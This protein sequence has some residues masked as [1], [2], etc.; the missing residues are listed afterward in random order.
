MNHSYR[1]GHCY[2]LLTPIAIIALIISI[3]LPSLEQARYLGKY[4]SLKAQATE[5]GA[6]LV[7][8]ESKEARDFA[9]LG[10][11]A[12]AK[13]TLAIIVE[14][15]PS[16]RFLKG[17][18]GQDWLKQKRHSLQILLGSALKA[19]EQLDGSAQA[20]TTS[21][22]DSLQNLSLAVMRM[23][24][25]N[26]DQTMLNGAIYMLSAIIAMTTAGL[27]RASW[28]KRQSLELATVRYAE[29]NREV[30]QLVTDLKTPDAP[31]ARAFASAGLLP[32]ALTVAQEVE[33]AR[34]KEA[35]FLSVPTLH[36]VENAKARLE[37]IHQVA[38]NR[39]K[40]GHIDW[41]Q[42]E[43]IEGSPAKALRSMLYTIYNL[44]FL[45]TFLSTC[46]LSLGKG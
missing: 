32:E 34:P 19:N 24:G 46:G 45:T 12:D 6:T 5:F 37:T 30:Q 11:I 23:E 28:R 29:A 22:I 33:N 4:A 18:E 38:S 41:W 9:K 1:R 44:K 40:H 8:S 7:E 25:L 10:L 27:L 3:L 36:W 16:S 43:N 42:R 31:L 39:L 26:P 13:R 2:D 15:F 35:A 20:E 17:P 14:D 21:S